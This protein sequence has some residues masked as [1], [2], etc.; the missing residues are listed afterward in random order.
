VT[1]SDELSLVSYLAD[2]LLIIIQRSKYI[3]P[4]IERFSLDTE[5]KLHYE[6]TSFRCLLIHSNV[7]FVI[8]FWSIL[9]KLELKKL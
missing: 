4:I 5:R 6:I 8:N 1:L 2:L 3:E 7:K 9:E